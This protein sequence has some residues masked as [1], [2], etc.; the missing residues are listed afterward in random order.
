M[1]VQYEN[2]FALISSDCIK[3][4]NN[5]KKL[6]TIENA[7]AEKK[8]IDASRWE[9]K[10]K[11]I[12][13]LPIF[14]DNRYYDDCKF[15]SVINHFIDDCCH[16]NP[17]NISTEIHVHESDNLNE[18]YFEKKGN[19]VEK[20]KSLISQK[21]IYSFDDLVKELPLFEIKTNSPIAKKKYATIQ[22]L[23]KVLKASN[24][25]ELKNLLHA[26]IQYLI[27]ISERN[28]KQTINNLIDDYADINNKSSGAD[29]M[30]CIYYELFNDG[31]LPTEN[32]GK[33]LEKKC[34]KI[35]KIIKKISGYF[36][37]FII[38]GDSAINTKEYKKEL[39]KL[40]NAD[41]ILKNENYQQAVAEN[42]KPKIEKKTNVA[43]K[44]AEALL[45]LQKVLKF[46]NWKKLKELL[47]AHIQ[48]LI[49]ISERKPKQTIGNLAENYVELN[50]K[51]SSADIINCIYYELFNDGILPSKNDDKA[52]EKKCNKIYKIIKHTNGYI[53][54][55]II[56]GDSAINSKEYKTKLE[57]LKHTVFYNKRQM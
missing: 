22:E 1:K 29:V 37:T 47:H 56:P 41:F 42:A 14:L 24:W 54:P 8:E 27:S 2:K 26:H 34:I 32:N 23:Q 25:E 15:K 44:K 7:Y 49:S 43:K 21:I 19:N 28:P 13:K 45:D 11:S 40:T 33:T 38:S 53:D 6:L 52:L 16:I 17:P 55:F 12:S 3:R 20:L 46:S 18:N 31:K 50:H 36:D 35:G 57:L 30:N 5:N 4:I 10:G 39:M 48:Y 9:A 51:N